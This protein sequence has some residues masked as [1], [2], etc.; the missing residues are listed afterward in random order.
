M[1]TK[2][3]GESGT[4]VSLTNFS[5]YSGLKRKPAFSGTAVMYSNMQVKVMMSSP[6][7]PPIRTMP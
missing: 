5:S 4:R 6:S 2:L 1:E 3:S 7:I